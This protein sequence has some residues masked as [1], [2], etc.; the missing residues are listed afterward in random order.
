[1]FRI[2]RVRMLPAWACL[3]VLVAL[4]LTGCAEEHPDTTVGEE[5]EDLGDAA[6]DAVDEAMDEGEDAADGEMEDTEEMPPDN[7]PH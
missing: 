6:F 5:M 7:G 4:P 3:V 1:M 2:D